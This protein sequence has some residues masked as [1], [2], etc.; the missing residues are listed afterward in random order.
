MTDTGYNE[1]KR[2]IWRTD[3]NKINQHVMKDGRLI[4]ERWKEKD[5]REED[6]KKKMKEKLKEEDEKR[7]LKEEAKRK[8]ERRS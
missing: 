6:E 3:I 7:K 4:D 5:E 1:G 2:P 8:A